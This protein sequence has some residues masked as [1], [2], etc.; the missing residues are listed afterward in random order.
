MTGMVA[1]ALGLKHN[2]VDDTNKQAQGTVYSRMKSEKVTT[3]LEDTQRVYHA[4]KKSGY[5]PDGITR[6]SETRKAA[7]KEHLEKMFSLGVASKPD[8]SKSKSELVS[9][10]INNKHNGS[11]TECPLCECETCKNRRYVDKSNDSAVSFQ[12]P[13]RMKPA[14][15]QHMVRAH[16][17][18]H[19]RREQQ[20]V[21]G[22]SDKRITSQSVQIHTDTCPECG[23]NYVSGGTTR[24]STRY[25]NSDYM[26][27]FKVGAP[28]MFTAKAGD[29]FT[30]SA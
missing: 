29:K 10:H 1:Q 24:T 22:N 30:S 12:K 16:E 17:M 3:G 9:D 4:E 6:D 26:E 11:H 13:T 18:E 15:A 14:E 2:N 8:N 25:V 23:K 20:K 19:V 27:L 21:A 7:R 28:D 5:D